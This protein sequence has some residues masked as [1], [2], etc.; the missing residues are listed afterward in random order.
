MPAEWTAPIELNVPVTAYGETV[1]AVKLR[2]PTIGELR[3]CGQPYN[4]VGN[5]GGAGVKADYDACARLLECV[6]DPPLPSMAI[7]EMDPAD[8]DELAMRLVGFT[9]RAP[10]GG[11]ANPSPQSASSTE[12]ATSPGSGA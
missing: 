3:K 2:R 7:D 5:G 11:S 4:V 10:R 12:P 8:F 9:K 1:S 6:C